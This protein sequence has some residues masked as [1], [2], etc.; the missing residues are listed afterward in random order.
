MIPFRKLNGRPGMGLHAGLPATG[1]GHA[2]WNYQRLQAHRRL[3]EVN[4]ALQRTRTE[5]IQL[6]YALNRPQL[7]H[8][9][10]MPAIEA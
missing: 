1:D 8:R 4:G 7:V 6:H 10:A 5:R 2:E 9:R 3:E